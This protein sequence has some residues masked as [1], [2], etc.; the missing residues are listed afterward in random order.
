MYSQ[1]APVNTKVGQYQ[2]ELISVLILSQYRYQLKLSHKFMN[3]LQHVSITHPHSILSIYSK[4]TL[5]KLLN[6]VLFMHT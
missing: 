3:T 6:L 1:T 4:V 5:F 2:Q